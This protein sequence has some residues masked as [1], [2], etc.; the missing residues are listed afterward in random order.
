MT[1]A[2]KLQAFLTVSPHNCSG[3]CQTVR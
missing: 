2:Y 1:V 3:S